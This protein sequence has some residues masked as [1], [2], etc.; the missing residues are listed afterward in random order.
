MP[1]GTEWVSSGEEVEA[2]DPGPPT[3]LHPVTSPSFL[4]PVPH[5]AFQPPLVFK[6]V[7]GLE[8][9][10]SWQQWVRTQVRGEGG[11]SPRCQ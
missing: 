9:G 7:T 5:Q 2:R 6:V 10:S 4:F 1:K 3:P 11:S 8:D